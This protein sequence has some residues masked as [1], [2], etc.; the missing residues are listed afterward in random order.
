MEQIR[1]TE[2][3]FYPE[4]KVHIADILKK[5]KQDIEELKTILRA[6]LNSRKTILHIEATREIAF[7]IQELW[8]KHKSLALRFSN[9]KTKY[10]DSVFDNE[11]ESLK[12]EFELVN[13]ALQ[14]LVKT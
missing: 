12:S 7:S 11:L 2:T 9:T 6:Y 4:H 1:S 13:K 10:D 8:Y 3:V 14:S 5:Y